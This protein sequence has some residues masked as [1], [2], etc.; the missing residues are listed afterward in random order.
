M[1][2][3][4][5]NY[6]VVQ[7][8]CFQQPHPSAASPRLCMGRAK[9]SGLQGLPLVRWKANG[10]GLT[11]TVFCGLV[12]AARDSPELGSPTPMSSSSELE[13]EPEESE[14]DDESLLGADT[15][16]SVRKKCGRCFL[17]HIVCFLHFLP[18]PSFLEAKIE[19]RVYNVVAFCAGTRLDRG[20]EERTYG[21][22]GHGVCNK[23]QKGHSGVTTPAIG[24]PKAREEKNWPKPKNVPRTL[25]L[26]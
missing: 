6:S 22:L 15:S 25:L 19:D 26:R 5:A 20:A 7:R 23:G 8:K 11:P 3:C 24:A 12:A 18:N 2:Q 1:A 10:G 17:C 9:T 21:T 13:E 16:W 14:L 4:I